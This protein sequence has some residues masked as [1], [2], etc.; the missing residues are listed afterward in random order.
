MTTSELLADIQR[1]IASIEVRAVIL[2]DRYEGR[3]DKLR[4]LDEAVDGLA[5]TPAVGV[6]YPGAG[7]FIPPLN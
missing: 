1:L 4:V 3:E 7:E 5:A 2:A 6:P